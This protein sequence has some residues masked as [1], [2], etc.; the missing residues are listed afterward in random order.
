MPRVQ[1]VCSREGMCSSSHCPSKD[2]RELEREQ[3]RGTKNGLWDVEDKAKRD[4]G[5]DSTEGK[6]VG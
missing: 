6:W 5:H 2:G 3:R 4:G 1:C